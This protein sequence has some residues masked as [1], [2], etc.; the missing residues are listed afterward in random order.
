MW[1]IIQR[2]LVQHIT[3]QSK[4]TFLSDAY[5]CTDAWNSRLSTP[6]LKKVSLDSFYYELDQKFLQQGK[7]SA[8]DIDIFANRL[9]DNNFHEELADLVHKL[10]MT[11]ETTN[12]LESMGHALIRLY[13]NCNNIKELLDILNDRLS[14]GVFLDSYLA[15]IAMDQFIKAKDFKSAA[16]ISTFMMLQETFDNKIT[17]G[18]SLY[19]CVKFLEAP[20]SFETKEPEQIVVSDDKSVPVKA[21]DKKKNKEEIKVRV[22]YIRNE[23]FDDHFDLN[24]SQLL[25]G[26]TLAMIGNCLIDSNHRALGESTKL[27]GLCLYRK[28]DEALKFVATIKD[29]LYKDAVKMAGNF[30]S[31]QESIVQESDENYK[32]LVDHVTKLSSS[33]LIEDSFEKAISKFTNDSVA[34]FEKNDIEK[35]I[36]VGEKKISVKSIIQ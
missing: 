30:L 25:V 22:G 33:K 4:R 29:G 23:Y 14:Y 7:A 17:M 12:S 10:R 1:K 2:T 36:K 28:Y 20:E 34:E 15:N 9:T 3:Q 32:K 27:L 24:D 21:A 26:K 11:E 18:M 16:R 13:L 31:Q 8:I 5:K 6:I 35:Q 19:G